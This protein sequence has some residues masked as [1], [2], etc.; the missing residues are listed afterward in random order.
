MQSRKERESYA[1]REGRQTCQGGYW[2]IIFAEHY[3]NIFASAELQYNDL[4]LN[5]SH[6]LKQMRG[7]LKQKKM[8]RD[9]SIPR[10]DLGLKPVNCVFYRYIPTGTH[11]RVHTRT[12][13]ISQVHFLGPGLQYYLGNINPVTSLYQIN[14]SPSN[15][16]CHKWGKCNA[17]PTALPYDLWLVT[18]QVCKST[19]FKT[20]RIT[21]NTSLHKL[22]KESSCSF[23]TWK[24]QT[25]FCPLLLQDLN[26]FLHE[27]PSFLSI[28]PS[29]KFSLFAFCS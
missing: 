19:P 12:R 14:D 13:T 15:S 9:T 27:A 20:S 4:E 26:V 10:A 16:F 25:Q 3:E 22:Q 17:P 5:G 6:L 7:N 1:S 23:C 2:V 8:C 29:N 21:V 18:V 28:M 11:A 24:E